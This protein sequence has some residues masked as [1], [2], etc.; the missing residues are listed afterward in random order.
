MATNSEQSAREI[1]KQFQHMPNVYFRFNV[2]QGLQDV[3]LGQWERLDDVRAST[4]DYML[5]LEVDQKLGGAALAIRERQRAVPI[6]QIGMN[7]E[8]SFVIL[9]LLSCGAVH[10]QP[11]FGQCPDLKCCPPPTSVFTGRRDILDQI[12]A[13]FSDVGKRCVVVLYGLG[14]AG[15]SQIAFKFI[16]ECQA[17]LDTHRY[18]DFHHSVDPV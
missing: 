2:E 15:K 17:D 10:I 12:H 13:C 8:L 9:C 6:A 4:E 1:A 7:L 18:A 14:G 3:R 5:M 16:E 11:P